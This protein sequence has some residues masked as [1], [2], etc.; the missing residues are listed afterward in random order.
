MIRAKWKLQATGLTS[1]TMGGP[2][3]TPVLVT[4]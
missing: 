1:V 2:V 4:G 3:M